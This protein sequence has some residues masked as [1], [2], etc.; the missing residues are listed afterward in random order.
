MQFTESTRKYILAGTIAFI[1]VGIIIAKVMASKQDEQFTTQ[2]T[3]Y[4]QATQLYNEG[5]YEEASKTLQSLLKQQ[6]NSEIVN[7][8]TAL[9]VANTGDSKKA[10]TLMEKIIQLNP[11]KVEDA[12]FMLQFGEILTLAQRYDDA[13]IVLTHCQQAAW[14]PADYPDYQ[15]RIAQLLTDIENK[16]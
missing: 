5:N 2:N 13:K 1:I 12:M 4:E 10:A 3:Q 14:V 11:H 8:L 7:Y 6:P 15:A 16:Q 9:S